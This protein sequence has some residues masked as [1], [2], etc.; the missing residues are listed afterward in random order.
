MAFNSGFHRERSLESN[1]YDY[2]SHELY[3]ITLCTCQRRCVFGS[4]VSGQ[5]DLNQWGEIVQSHWLDLPQHCPWLQL[6]EWVV[7]PNHFHGIV[8]LSHSQSI[9]EI[10][11]GF[12]ARSS[13]HINQI[14]DEVGMP[15]WQ[16][17]DYRHPIRNATELQKIRHCIQTNPL[18]WRSDRLHPANLSNW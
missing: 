7:M 9:P 11:H 10:I 4:I 12:K 13:R 16:R 17:N 14:R 8:V 1:A 15:I 3:F 6:D 2:S 18:A 5:V